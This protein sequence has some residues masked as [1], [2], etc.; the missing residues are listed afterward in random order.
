MPGWSEWL[1]Q[2]LYEVKEGEVIA[3]NTPG[4][5]TSELEAGSHNFNDIITGM[6]VVGAHWRDYR[7]SENF[8]LGEFVVSESRPDLLVGQIPSVKVAQALHLLVVSL[9]QQIRNRWG[10]VVIT[11]GWR[12]KPLNDVFS[13]RQDSDH[14]IAAADFYCPN[15][16]LKKVFRWIVKKSD[17]PF[18]QCYLKKSGGI[19]HISGN[20]PARAGKYRYRNWW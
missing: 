7:L 8:W 16:K 11:S 9:M 1:Q 12:P 17:L 2:R 20:L 13:T 18:R 15:V 3:M 10:E 4:V 14:L 19:I 5:W 6:D